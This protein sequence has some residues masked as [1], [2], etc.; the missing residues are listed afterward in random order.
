MS[1]FIILLPEPVKNRGYNTQCSSSAA[2][3]EKD[4][5]IWFTLIASKHQNMNL[6]VS[7]MKKYIALKLNLESEDEVE[8]YLRKTLLVPSIML[9]D[10]LRYW[11]VTGELVTTPNPERVDIRTG[12][13]GA[14][15][16]MVLSYTR[17]SKSA[18]LYSQ[19]YL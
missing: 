3:K 13:S 10:L 8:L 19:G 7:Y 11:M 6:K 14:E 16:I 17:K 9:Q 4:T 12:C 15:Y 2:F 5:S 1:T 18:T